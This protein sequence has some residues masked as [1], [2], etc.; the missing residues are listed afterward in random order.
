[1][2]WFGGLFGKKDAQAM[3][4]L[5]SGEV[6]TEDALAVPG[7]SVAEARDLIN[8]AAYETLQLNGIPKDWL[9]F[10]ILTLSDAAKAYFQLQVTIR[11]WDAYLLMHSFAFEQVVV[12]RVRERSLPISRALRAVLW[13][14]AADANCPYDRMPPSVAWTVD[15][16]AQRENNGDLFKAKP[17]AEVAQRDIEHSEEDFPATLQVASSEEADAALAQIMAARQA[18]QGLSKD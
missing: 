9:K 13:R 17:R 3:E 8:R 12:P 6:D 15:A 16:I 5:P 10:E 7:S 18:Q 4:I 1:M 11:H 14:V 2:A